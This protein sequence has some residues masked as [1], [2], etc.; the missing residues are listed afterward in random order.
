MGL[1]SIGNRLDYE[2]C[3][4]AKQPGGLRGGFLMSDNKKS[5]FRGGA[6]YSTLILKKE[7]VGVHNKTRNV[8]VKPSL[9]S[10]P[11]THTNQHLSMFTA[12]DLL[13]TPS[14]IVLFHCCV[15]HTLYQVSLWHALDCYHLTRG[16]ILFMQRGACWELQSPE[17]S[18]VPSVC[19][20]AGEHRTTTC[21]QTRLWRNPEALCITVNSEGTTDIMNVSCQSLIFI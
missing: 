4:Y 7:D 21:C 5:C 1:L 6:S 16:T 9:S 18:V 19:W 14:A 13:C 8:C 3:V 10:S 2:K 12:Q 11:Y 17:W 20:A 15:N